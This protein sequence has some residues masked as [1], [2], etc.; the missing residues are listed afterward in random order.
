MLNKSQIADLN[1]GDK[2]IKNI[3]YPHGEVNSYHGVVYSNDIK[4]IIINSEITSSGVH[5]SSTFYLETFQDDGW[6]ENDFHK[7]TI[8]LD[9]TGLERQ[10]SYGGV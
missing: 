5:S 9:Q 2:V 7:Y 6:Y 3:H 8:E 1:R 4:L 10:Y